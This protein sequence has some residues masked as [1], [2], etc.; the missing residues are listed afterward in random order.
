MS[1]AHDKLRELHYKLD[2]IFDEINGAID[3]VEEWDEEHAA[4]AFQNAEF[5][6][7]PDINGELIVSVRCEELSEDGVVASLEKMPCWL[8]TQYNPMEMNAETELTFRNA[9]KTRG[10]KFIALGQRYLDF[11]EQN[12][13][14]T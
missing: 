6:L 7:E 12:K 13:P 14:E 8:L 11:L 5:S 4:R 10:E 3:K 1:E 2:D 9:I